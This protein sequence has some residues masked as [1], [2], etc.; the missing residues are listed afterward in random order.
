MISVKDLRVA[1]TGGG[2]FLGKYIVDELESAGCSQVMVVRSQDYD[3]RDAAAVTRLFR[4]QRPDVVIHAAATVGG[5]GANRA[6]PADFFYENA[7]MGIH[8]IEAARR[9]DTEKVVVLGTVC[10]YP[11]FAK[12]PFSEDDLWLGYPEETN[13]PYGI[14][15]KAL[16][17]QCQAYREQYGLNAIYLLPVNLYGPHDHFDLES[18]HV[19]PALIRKCLEAVDRGASHIELWGDGSATREFLFARDAA[20]GIIAATEQ[21]DKPEPVNIGS[22]Q[23]ISILELAHLIAEITGFRG[24]LVWDPS[25]PNGQPRRCLDVTRARREFGFEASTS[26]R[27]GLSE[28]IA[29]YQSTRKT[30][31]AVS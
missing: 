13:A 1:V 29:W 30:L 21:Y 15:K 24:E 11:K 14:A 10:A 4:I 3:L 19:I 17:V 20:R 23:E 2:G 9:F 12:V 18:S 27:E 5:I 22:G 7:L 25:K 6:R 28:T 16:M 26:L 31:E 8:L